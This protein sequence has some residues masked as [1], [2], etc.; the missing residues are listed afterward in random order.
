MKILVCT[1]GSKPA[2]KAV[3]IAAQL[4]SV[5]KSPLM[6]LHVIGSEVIRKEPIYDEYGE[7]YNKAKSII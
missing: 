2:E 6:I 4:A 7:K 5:S 3:R 1:D